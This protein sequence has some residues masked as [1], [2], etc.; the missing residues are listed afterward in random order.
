MTGDPNDQVKQRQMVMLLG[1]LMGMLVLAGVGMFMFDGPKREGK[2]R[3]ATTRLTVP[4]NVDDKD[5]WRSQMAARDI[6]HD[7]QVSALEARVKAHEAE[8]KKIKDD[9]DTRAR[10][11]PGAASG[12]ALSVASRPARAH[13]L[14]DLPLIET[15]RTAASQ[16]TAIL[17]EPLNRPVGR[18]MLPPPGG[19]KGS[20]PN[21]VNLRMGAVEREPVTEERRD[22]V[23]VIERGRQNDVDVSGTADATNVAGAAGAAGATGV[24]GV[25]IKP[26]PTAS[27]A[28][29]GEASSANQ[30]GLEF[31]PAGSFVRVV[32]LN[33]VDAPTGGQ[34]QSNPLPIALE[35]L[36]TANLANRYRLDIRHCR[37]IVAAWGEL[38]SE[39]TLGRTESLTCVINGEA[40]EMP[41]KGV[42]IDEDGK[43]GIR[44]RLVSKQGQVLANAVLAGAL[45]GLGKAFQ[46][47]ATTTTA[48]GGGITQSIDPAR[49]GQAALGGGVST[50]STMLADYYLKAADKLY[51]VIETD[52]GR[53]VEVLITKGAVFK[54]GSRVREQHRSLL[55]A[56]RRM[57]KEDDDD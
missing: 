54:G 34:A 3:P 4:G 30:A 42:L 10:S 13:V 2:V 24:A 56:G 46:A 41:V 1:G 16:S 49:V 40:V 21:A 57:G 8:L 55:S 15:G 17:D 36:D 43:A 50:A 5:A 11:G 52:G 33:G 47:A 25:V 27:R 32:M 53:V 39:R 29:V 44:G 48:G 7:K 31:L 12:P 6:G 51:P 35:V 14:N 37:I 19:R 18:Q 26:R 38:S 9:A 28:A 23:E 45:G 20:G 22:A